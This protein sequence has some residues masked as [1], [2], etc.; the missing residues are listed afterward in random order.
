MIGPYTADLRRRC[1]TALRV[2]THA[3]ADR[4]PRH[5]ARSRAQVGPARRDGPFI[6]V[7]VIACITTE[8]PL[9]AADA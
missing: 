7:F 8:I 5:V 1:C 9:V 4:P 6:Y 2:Q 3:V